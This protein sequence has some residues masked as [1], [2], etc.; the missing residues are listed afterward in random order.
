MVLAITLQG[1][2]QQISCFSFAIAH[3]AATALDKITEETRFIPLKSTMDGIVTMSDLPT[4]DAKYLR[5]LATVETITLGKPS[6]NSRIAA[7][8]IS[9]F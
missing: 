8:H 1:P 3:I 9:V 7:V 4:T 5:P 2:A 6:G